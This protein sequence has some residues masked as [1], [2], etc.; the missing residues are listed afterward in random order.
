[1]QHVN[2]KEH[3]EAIEVIDLHAHEL[4]DNTRGMNASDIL[5]YQL[6]VFRKIMEQHINQKGKKIVFIHG[7]GQG[8]LRNALLLLTHVFFQLM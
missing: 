2:H 5:E 4:L 3:K 6:D 8:V 7:K 1:M